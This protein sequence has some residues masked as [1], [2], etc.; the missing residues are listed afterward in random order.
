M[1]LPES[2]VQG[3]A[4]LFAPQSLAAINEDY[5]L[6]SPDVLKELN[7]NVRKVQPG[8]IIFT[9]TPGPFFWGIRSLASS[10]YDHIVTFFCQKK[11]FFVTCFAFDA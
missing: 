9:S 5:L 10:R 2:L 8:D 6:N 3:I 7:K 1:A 4:K 11:T